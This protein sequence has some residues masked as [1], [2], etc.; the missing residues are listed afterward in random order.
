MTIDVNAQWINSQLPIV[1]ASADNELEMVWFTKML[2][3]GESLFDMLSVAP[4][5]YSNLM[6][7]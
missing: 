5:L 4:S 2:V 1:E 3:P 7:T 6:A